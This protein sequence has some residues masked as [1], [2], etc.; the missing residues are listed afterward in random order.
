[1]WAIIG[2]ALA[3]IMTLGAGVSCGVLVNQWRKG[4]G[5]TIFGVSPL[6]YV[7]GGPGSRHLAYRLVAPPM[8]SVSANMR[9]AVSGV[10]SSWDTLETNCERIF[11]SRR[12]RC[13]SQAMGADY[14]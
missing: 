14:R 4:G 2:F 5:A 10:L 12:S 1:V 7:M 11:E 8:R 13:T 3:C 6:F 9:M